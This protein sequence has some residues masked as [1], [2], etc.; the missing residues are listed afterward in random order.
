MTFSWEGVLRTQ[1]QATQDL[2]CVSGTWL[3]LL[4]DTFKV[5]V[6]QLEVFSTSFILL[7]EVVTLLGNCPHIGL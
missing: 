6:G 4:V 7:I 3:T 2:H 1:D 5:N